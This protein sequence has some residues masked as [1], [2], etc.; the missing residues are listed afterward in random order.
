[1]PRRACA[2]PAHVAVSTVAVAADMDELK[3][4]WLNCTFVQYPGESGMAPHVCKVSRNASS[5]VSASLLS[6]RF[7]KNQHLSKLYEISTKLVHKLVEKHPLDMPE[8]GWDAAFNTLP[9]V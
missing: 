8:P 4:M 9:I 5:R 2:L 7:D 6:V 3:T 1:M